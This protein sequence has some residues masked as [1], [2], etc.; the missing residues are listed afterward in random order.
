LETGE[1]S[2]LSYSFPNDQYKVRGSF[3]L[4]GKSDIFNDVINYN[5]DYLKTG[6]SIQWNSIGE[7]NNLEGKISFL[8]KNFSIDN[9]IPNSAFLNTLK[10]LNLDAIVKN[11]DS[12][13]RRQDLGLLNLT[14]ASGD[15][16]FSKKRGLISN[17]ISIE[18][19]E[20]KMLWVGE[21][22]KNEMGS[23][24]MLNL[25]MSLRIKISENLPWYAAIFG[26]IPAV[27]GTLVFQDLFEE[28][29]DA[30]S[31]ISFKVDGTIKNPELVRLN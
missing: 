12:D 31:S 13:T 1:R 17:P 10:I 27:A 20:A 11:L 29:I 28:N 4:D 3:E 2:F 9:D 22:L 30:A 5:F 18:T 7:L 26:G 19:D 14:R 16:L 25:D 23:L 15:I 8:T 21:I 24:E 6:M